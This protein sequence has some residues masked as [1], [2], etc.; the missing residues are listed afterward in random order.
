MFAHYNRIVSGASLIAGPLVLL[1][2]SFF[3]L[4]GGGMDSDDTGGT[5]QILAFFLFIF[6]VL[7]LTQLAAERAPRAAIVLR[8]L[9]VF[10]CVYGVINGVGSVL[11]D[12]AGAGLTSLPSGLAMLL[13][14][15]GLAFPLSLLALGLLL[16]RT[17]TVPASAGIALALGAFLFPVGRIPDIIAV[18]FITDVLLIVSMGWIGASMLQN[19]AA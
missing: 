6:G 12:A 11:A 5:L 9:L 14:F 15:P 10:G 16:W 19:R 18:Y 7:G 1:A 8:V 13:I 4:T 3:H 17:E 2:S